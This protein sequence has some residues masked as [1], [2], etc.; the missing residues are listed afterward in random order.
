MADD[1]DVALGSPEVMKKTKRLLREGGVEFEN[2]FV[3]SSICCPSR[4]SI[5]TGRYAHNHN[6]MSNKAGCCNQEWRDGPEKNNFGKL[7]QEAG[8]RTGYFGK[9]LNRYMGDYVPPG[10]DDWNGLVKN[11]RF[12]NYTLNRNG[13]KEK[14]YA[15]YEK[16]YFTNVITDLSLRFFR[17]SKIKDYYKPVMMVISHA[18]PH[19]PED[20]APHHKDLLKNIQAPRHP[21]FNV[22]DKNKH[23]VVRSRP[24]LTEA[25]GKFVDLLH[26]RRLLTLLALDDAI[27]RVHQAIR[28]MR[29]LDNTYIFFSSDHGYKLGQF[30]LVKGKAQPYET[31]IHVPM[32]VMGPGVPVN[33]TSKAVVLNIDLL[34]TFLDIAGAPRPD[35]VDGS[36][37]LSVLTT[38]KKQRRFYKNNPVTPW[39]DTFL[40]E[41]RKTAMDLPEAGHTIKKKPLIIRTDPFTKLFL[42]LKVLGRVPSQQHAGYLCTRPNAPRAPCAPSKRWICTVVHQRFFIQ[43]CSRRFSARGSIKPRDAKRGKKCQCKS[44]GKPTPPPKVESATPSLTDKLSSLKRRVNILASREFHRKLSSGGQLTAHEAAMFARILMRM[45]RKYRKR[46]LRRHSFQELSHDELELRIRETKKRLELLRHRKRLLKAPPVIV[47]AAEEEK[48]NCAPVAEPVKPVNAKKDLRKEKKKHKNLKCFAVH[49]DTW[50][51]PPRW[52]GGDFISC[53]NSP[54]NSYWCLRT[55]NSTHNFLYCRFV[56]GFIEY[57][58]IRTDPYQLRNI[59]TSLSRE[60]LKDMD[61]QIDILKLC[62]GERHCTMTASNSPEKITRPR[63]RRLRHARGK[64][65]N[66]RKY[67]GLSS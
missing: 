32:Y 46:T 20:P 60:V 57:Y 11:S 30:S 8:Y 27:A 23:W 38:K 51:T 55:I 67:L 13:K 63:F 16:D 22:T 26:R 37:L 28:R 33:K 29:M 54:N 25:N 41:R 4:S 53:I 44:N 19:G 56:T 42:R 47:A 17:K 3:T 5:L 62:K 39:R 34:P 65:I 61:R 35:Y 7:L 31:D 40:V 24:H 10:W 21:N 2:A 58:D 45:Q 48:C 6:V 18:A 9:Y 49:N 43:Q 50:K 12:Y 52:Y 36:S 14:H 15:S 1:L 59:Y 64:Y 66:W